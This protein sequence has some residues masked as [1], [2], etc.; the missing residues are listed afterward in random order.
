IL[1]GEEGAAC[2]GARR[3][4]STA[5]QA[6]LPPLCYPGE[7]AKG[8][9]GLGGNGGRSGRSGQYGCEVGSDGR[10][11]RGYSQWGYD[12]ADYISLAEDLSSW[13]AADTAALITQ[14]KWVE[15]G[16][17]EHDRAYLEGTCVEWLRRYLENGK[18]TLQHADPPETHV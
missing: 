11:L 17:A 13:V 14:R 7:A 6:E 2:A 16:A 4:V 9:S 5:A 12:G 3:T 15:A 1:G 18:E 8:A 10:L